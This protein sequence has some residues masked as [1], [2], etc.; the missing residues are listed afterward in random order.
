MD[1]SG[2]MGP[3]PSGLQ[4]APGDPAGA[5]GP[6]APREPW[7]FYKTIFFRGLVDSL[8]KLLV[9]GLFFDLIF[10][11]HIIFFH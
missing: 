3:D 6:G 4:L 9:F 10:G 5:G 7:G 11:L 8:L 2:H 1:G